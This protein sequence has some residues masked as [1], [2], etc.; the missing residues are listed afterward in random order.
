MI[1]LSLIGTR[2]Q[3]IKETIL[4]EE[5]KKCGIREIIVDSGQHYD[6]NMSEIFLKTL[7]IKKPDYNLNIGSGTHAE[8]I[9]KIMVN[10]EKIVEKIRPNLILVYGDTNTTLAGAIVASKMK[11]K[12]AHIEAGMRSLPKNAPEEINRVM[13][14]RIS[15]YLFCPSQSAVNNLNK[16]NIINNVY[17]VGDVMYDL[18]LKMK[19]KASYEVFNKLEIKRENFVLLTLHRDYNVDDEKKLKKILVSLGKINKEM[20][21]IFPIHPRTRKRILEFGLN[22][23]I[24]NLLVIEPV[25]YLN[26]M[27]LVE[28]SFKVITDSGGLQKEAYFAKKRAIVLMQ[29]TAWKELIENKCNK[30]GNE[31]TLLEDVL[32][33]EKNFYEPN[34][35]GDGKSGKKIINILLKN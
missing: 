28:K 4:N 6:P 23:Y 15:D 8:T 33:E 32:K 25:D 26:M 17:F 27:G 7:N 3:Y 21:I 29:D 11:I 20:P 14:D 18:Y 2:P 30:L 1:I 19:K 5:F 35:Y 9:G 34:I 16:E 13:T 22:K 31:N 12:L 10:F 24:D